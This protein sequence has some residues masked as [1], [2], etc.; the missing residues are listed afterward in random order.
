MKKEI[1]MKQISQMGQLI[2]DLRSKSIFRQFIPQEA[3]I[4][5]PIPL[6]Q[7]EQIYVTFIFFGMSYQPDTQQNMLFPPFATLT[8]NWANQHLVKYVDLYFENPWPEGNW[9]D[10]AGTFP[11]AAVA[12][13]SVGEYE[14]KRQ[15]LFSMYDEMLEILRQGTSFSPEWTSAFQE[16]LRLL[17][18]PEL[19][20]F[21][22]ALAPKFFGHFLTAE[23]GDRSA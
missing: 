7:N 23:N 12:N 14:E 19:E 5:W 16:N 6:R 10:S 9:Q 4:G 20:P 22:R 3:G 1:I 11:H 21:Y 17:M 2:N 18:E 15:E 13:L 8:L